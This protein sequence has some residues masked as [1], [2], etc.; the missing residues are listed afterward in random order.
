MDLFSYLLGKKSGGGGITPTGT[1]N[2][3][4]NGT[5]DVTNYASAEVETS[6]PEPLI[7]EAYTQVAWLKS[8]GTQY[9]DTGYKPNANTVINL[10]GWKER[11]GALFGVREGSN[12]N[13]YFLAS[14]AVRQGSVIVGGNFLLVYGDGSEVETTDNSM[15]NSYIT[16]S[17]SDFKINGVSHVNSITNYPDL[18][19]YLYAI[20][21][22]GTADSFCNCCISNFQVVENNTVLHNLVPCYRNVDG[23]RGFYDTVTEDFL[24]NSGTGNFTYQPLDY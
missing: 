17:S 6:T 24:T 7:P 19:L 14:K 21:T 5:Y 18:N 20:N 22:A 13:S 16:I 8:N 3:T 11:T 4:E 12:S 1:I 9:I 10:I 2:I 23:V 15:I